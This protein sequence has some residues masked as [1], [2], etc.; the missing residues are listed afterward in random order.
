MKQLALLIILAQIGSYVPCSYFSFNCRKF[1]YS[2]FNLNSISRDINNNQEYYNDKNHIKGNF[3][4]QIT[5][6]QSVIN[7][8]NYNKSLILLDEPFENTHSQLMIEIIISLMDLFA[9]NLNSSFIIISSH[10]DIVNR[11]SSFYFHS[12]L[13]TMKV[14][15][16]NESKD[17]DFLYKFKFTPQY[18]FDIHENKEI[19]NYGINLCKIIGLNQDII[20][21]AEE[22]AENYRENTFDELVKSSLEMNILKSFLI[23]L[24]KNMFEIIAEKK[25]YT[26]KEQVMVSIKN[27]YNFIEKAII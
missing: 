12:I 25:N 26:I 11:L 21:Y 9:K 7:N 2:N 1:L 5:E 6:I 27:L 23:K 20:K 16:N 10:N 24:Y 8:K 14:E 18:S 3:I 15:I 17:F 4:K 19:K 13:G 22:I